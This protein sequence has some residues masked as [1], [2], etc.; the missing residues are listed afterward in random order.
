MGV[1]AGA[2]TNVLL[3]TIAGATIF[4]GLPIARWK[5][6]SENLR[7]TLALAASGVL[8]FL[9]IE[10]GYHAIEMV[11]STAKGGDLSFA[12]MQ[13]GILVVG[14]CIGLVGLGVIEENRA[15]KRAEGASALEIATMIAIGIGLHNFA[16]GLA[17]GQSFSGGQAS[18]GFILVV[19]F[20]LHN[21]TEG[22]GIAAPLAGQQVSW[23]RLF[24]LGLIGG[25]PTAL[26]AVLGGTFVN[27]NV[28]LLFLSLAVGSLIYVTRELLR[29]RFSSPIGAAAMSALAVGLLVGIF[30]EL[31]VEV[32]SAKNMTSKTAVAGANEITFASDKA[33]PASIEIAR[34]KSLNLTNKTNRA[35]EFEGHGLVAGEVVVPPKS[36][37]SIVIT[38]PEGSYSLSPEGG[39]AGTAVIKV[40]GGGISSQ[41]ELAL[42]LAAITTI[43]GHANAAH[44]L[45]LRALSGKSPNATLDLKRAGKHAHHPMHELLEDKSPR[46]L[47][48]QELL[49]KIGMLDAFKE[50]L[51]SYSHLAG[52]KDADPKSFA[53]S[54]VQL[55]EMVEKARTAIG[56]AQ[57]HEPAFKAHVAT[58]LLS[59]GEGEYKEAVEG[60]TVKVIEEAVPGKDAFLEYQDTRGFLKASNRILERLSKDEFKEDG[61]KAMA[62]LLGDEFKTVDPADPN[63]PVPYETIE[64]LFDRIEKSVPRN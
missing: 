50:Q 27:P 38:G 34:G 35:L 51:H 28:E 41:D 42:T 1:L 26:G 29:L 4:L 22:F 54:Y 61:R 46:A 47:V 8:I 9:I 64:K 44:D 3:G 33:E 13:F 40:A 63:H 32:A 25:G 52:D 16:E 39:G 55:I 2:S 6:A 10:V 58:E 15:A 21:A 17:I 48:V 36:T 56:G 49:G 43:E 37:I 12:A 30:T 45:H 31:F 20:A 14:L 60:G 11:E 24:W 7:G 5:G 59:M 57:Y 18:L 19:G 23:T 53:E 62:E